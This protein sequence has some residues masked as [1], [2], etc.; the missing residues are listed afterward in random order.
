MPRAIKVVVDLMFS[1]RYAILKALLAAKGT[2]GLRL[3][4]SSAAVIKCTQN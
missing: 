1:D 3:V 4:F 2:T